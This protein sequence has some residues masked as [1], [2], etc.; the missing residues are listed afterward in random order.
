MPF[1]AASGVEGD[2]EDG[3]A[4][5]LVEVEEEE[6]EAEEGAWESEPD[7]GEPAGGK[8]GPV[9]DGGGKGAGPGDAASRGLL[10]SGRWGARMLKSGGAVLME[11]VGIVDWVATPPGVRRPDGIRPLGTMRAEGTEPDGRGVGAC[12]DGLTCG[13]AA[14][15]P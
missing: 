12:R 15:L 9:A 11:V 6:E 3:G 4:D 10:L 1:S 7:K 13:V 2:D 14:P 8:E 5:A